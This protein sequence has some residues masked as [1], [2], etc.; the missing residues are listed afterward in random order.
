[1]TGDVAWDVENKMENGWYV[2]VWYYIEMPKNSLEN[3][4]PGEW[5]VIQA[6]FYSQTGNHLQVKFPVRSV[7]SKMA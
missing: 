5:L 7:F 6:F 4:S 2:G 3:I 1:M